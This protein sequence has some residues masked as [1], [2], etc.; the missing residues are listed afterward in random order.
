VRESITFNG[1]EWAGNVELGVEKCSDRD[2]VSPH[3]Y[4][5]WLPLCN[6]N[7]IVVGNFSQSSV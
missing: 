5:L 3:T 2:A 4:F 7:K 1:G 6:R